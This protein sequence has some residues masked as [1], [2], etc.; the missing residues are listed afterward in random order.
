ME[1]YFEEVV[2][3]YFECRKRKRNSIYATEFEFDLEKNLFQLFEDLKN[4][5]YQIGPSIAFA[6][7]QPKIRE[8]W[9]ASF[10]DRVVHH[11]IYNRLS[12]KYYPSFIRNTFAC[13][14]ERGSM[15]ASNYLWSGMRSI[16]Q[17]W[18]KKSYFLG[19]DV[20]NFFVS[21]NKTILFDLL[22]IRITEPW[23]LNLTKQVLFH[24]PRNNCLLHSTPAV[25]SRVPKHK[26]LWQTPKER[27]LP[28]GNLTSQFF[29]NVYLNELDQFVKHR[30]KIKY[31]Y[32]YVDDFVILHEEP[33]VLN[34]FFDKI[35]K[36]V[37]QKLKLELHPFKK[38]LGRVDQGIDFV[39]YMHKPFRRYARKRTVN[40]LQSR[41][42]QWKK[43]PNLFDD[44]VLTN[45]RN[46]VNS[47]YGTIK[48]TASYNLR[49]SI[50]QQVNSL[51]IQPD[52]KYT[53]LLKYS[54]NG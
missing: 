21:I 46:S 16:T 27:G 45:L 50:G 25:F 14:P 28:I 48:H 11:I 33:N 39:G 7:E 6:V 5:T 17:N 40:R 47:Y 3:A 52:E 26:S 41:V 19:G 32:R 23:L 8:I 36:F 37:E 54:N 51:F 38:R 2:L 20:R 29:A 44:E 53:K 35:K 30:L 42:N 12:P 34:E 4:E 18:Q 24:D 15:E 1:L 13:I 43:N 10:R 9:A 49:K 31:Y 22:R